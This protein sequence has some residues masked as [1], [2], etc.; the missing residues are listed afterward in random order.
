MQLKIL[1]DKEEKTVIFFRKFLIS[2]ILFYT[3]TVIAIPCENTF[4][5]ASVLNGSTSGKETLNGVAHRSVLPSVETKPEV[6]QEKDIE[7]I[8]ALRERANQ[9]QN[10]IW[11]S[12]FPRGHLTAIND[13][14][15]LTRAEQ[16]DLMYKM[17]SLPEYS[18]FDVRERV[19][20][21]KVLLADG[22]DVNTQNA[23]GEGLLHIAVRMRGI[24]GR[25]LVNFLLRN[26]ADVQVEN[27]H[28]QTPLQIAHVRGNHELVQILRS[29]L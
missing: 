27:H 1:L 29:S 4:E 17:V 16:I 21:L 7:T 14:P 8:E 2:V 22:V 6:Q 12:F 19:K 28:G 9:E 15:Q 25:K 18:T 24:A 20:W 13:L 11:E 23:S 10:V 3:Y 26:G 5:S